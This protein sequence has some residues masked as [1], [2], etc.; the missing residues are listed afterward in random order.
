MSKTTGEPAGHPDF[1]ESCAPGYSGTEFEVG[2]TSCEDGLG[3][4]VHALM[5]FLR[6]HTKAVIQSELKITC[7]WNLKKLR[8]LAGTNITRCM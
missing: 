1:S 2:R 3:A 5:I 6:R 4:T 7:R 8:L